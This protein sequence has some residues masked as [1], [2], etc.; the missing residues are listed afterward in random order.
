LRVP[1]HPGTTF[2]I[3][4]RSRHRFAFL[5]NAKSRF[6]RQIVVVARDKSG[7]LPA[8]RCHAPRLLEQEKHIGIFASIERVEIWNFPTPMCLVFKLLNKT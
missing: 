4:V 1:F 6:R 3:T 2:Q 5:I 7:P 8:R